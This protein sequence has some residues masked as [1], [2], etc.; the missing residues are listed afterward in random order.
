MNLYLEDTRLY[1]KFVK[2]IINQCS[3]KTKRTNNL[4]YIIVVVEYRKVTQVCLLY[5]FFPLLQ[6]S[7]WRVKRVDQQVELRGCVAAYR[8]GVWQYFKTVS[9]IFIIYPLASVFCSYFRGK[10]WGKC[11][12]WE[13]GKIE[14]YMNIK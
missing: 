10:L 11:S 13:I 12:G 1:P 9:S 5:C 8:R 6:T 14:I 7:K 3:G 2:K 4:F